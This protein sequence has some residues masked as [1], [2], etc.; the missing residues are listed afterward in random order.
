MKT[1]LNQDRDCA[2]VINDH[3]IFYTHPTS[4]SINL[5]VDMTGMTEDQE[6]KMIPSADFDPEEAGRIRTCDNIQECIE[7][8]ES[9]LDSTEPVVFVEGYFG[10]QDEWD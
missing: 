8:I 5:M 2:Y 4:N 6:V 10:G 7:T 3:P 9:I 1:I